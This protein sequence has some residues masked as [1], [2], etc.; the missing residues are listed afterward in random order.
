MTNV[1]RLEKIVLSL[2]GSVLLELDESINGGDILTIMGRSG[3]GKSSLL[4][5]IGGF[6]DSVFSYS[7]RVFFNGTD[8]TTLPSSSRRMGLLFQDSLLFPHLSVG[9]NLLFAL[10]RDSSRS[11]RDILARDALCNVDLPDF[12]DRDPAT[13]SGG[14]RA[15]VAL[16]R[17]LISRPSA[18]LLD[19]P[20]SKLDTDL[21]D[22]MR[23]LV[24]TQARNQ[25]LPVILVSHDEADAMAA[26]GKIIRLTS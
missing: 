25:N 10:P 9:E 3:S 8:I 20:F 15:R 26:G 19:E 23:H 21:R 18:L 5:L 4:A 13:L 2:H 12:F 11:D 22:Q 17:V 6:L 14:Q 1:L 7:G 16:A 24:F